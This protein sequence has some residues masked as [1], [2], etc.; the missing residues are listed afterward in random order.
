MYYAS[1]SRH[2]YDDYKLRPTMILAASTAAGA[3]KLIDNGVA[4]DS[5]FPAGTGYLV[6]TTDGLR[7]RRMG[8]FQTTVAQWNGPDKIA[9]GGFFLGECRLAHRPSFFFARRCRIAA[10]FIHVANG[11]AG[12]PPTVP[13]GSTSRISPAFAAIRAPAPMLK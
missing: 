8:Q 3:H 5:T 6:R 2:P 12:I 10:C 11:T 4:A 9:L 13:P 7:S 1:A